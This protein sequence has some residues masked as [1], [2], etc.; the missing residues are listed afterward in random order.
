MKKTYLSILAVLILLVSGCVGTQPPLEQ[1]IESIEIS[2][3][4]FGWAGQEYL[5]DFIN[6]SFYSYQSEKI[7][8]GRD[9]SAKNAGYTYIGSLNDVNGFYQTAEQLDFFNWQER[10]D[11]LE[12][13]DGHQW[14]I[15]ITYHDGASKHIS[16]SNAYPKNWEL[17]GAVF[18]KLTTINVLN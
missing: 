6:N 14:S 15:T 18:Q 11:N 1:N 13:M 8:E 16:G 10:Y 7:G 4:S 5:I 12:I 2:H 17:M 9:E 3:S